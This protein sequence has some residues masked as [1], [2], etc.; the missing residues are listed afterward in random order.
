M[1]VVKTSTAPIASTISIVG[2]LLRGPPDQTLYVKEFLRQSTIWTPLSVTLTE[3][4]V[5]V[6]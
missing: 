6:Q 1:I 5:E 3:K 4:E 2:F